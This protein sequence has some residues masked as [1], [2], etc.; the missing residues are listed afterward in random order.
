MP[1]IK[2]YL[3]DDGTL[4][5]VEWAHYLE[6]A[7]G[8]QLLAVDLG[9]RAVKMAH[10]AA[11]GAELVTNGT[12]GVDVIR[13]AAGDGFTPHTHPGDHLLIVVGGQ[14]TITYDGKVYP[15]RAGQVYMVE[16]SIPHAVGAITDHVILA[17]GCPHKRVDS[18][19]RMAPVAYQE[20]V[21]DIKTLHCLICEKIA[22]YPERLHAKGCPHCPCVECHPEGLTEEERARL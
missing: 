13:L 21:A 12:L 6:A 18:D 1:Q 15:T 16:G 3:M 5:L 2:P 22:V 11:T 7:A 14:G 8:Q 4:R 19:D 9:P 20:V 17:V 10:S